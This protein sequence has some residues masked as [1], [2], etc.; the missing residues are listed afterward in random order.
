MP[1]GVAGELYIGGAGLARGYLNRPELTAERFIPNPFSD[2]PAVPGS[3][4]PA[5]WCA[6][7]ADGNLEFL[8]RLDHQ[9]KIR[10]FRIEL[11]EI[12]AA[13]RPASGF[14]AAVVVAREDEPG[15]QAAGGLRR[16]S[17]E[18]AC[19]R[20]RPSCGSFL[21]RRLPEYMVPSA[22]VV[23]DRLP[24]TPNGKVDRK[25]LPAPAG[26]RPEPESG[27]VAPADA[28]GGATGGRSGRRC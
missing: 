15:R 20:R 14:A 22:F 10:G 4:G 23:L 16:A 11:G 17:A 3:T 13:L 2:G 5:T 26:D 12:E 28:D 7:L 27:Y 18:P 24:L 9:V 1:V 19:A 21:S 25:A 8:G 6:W